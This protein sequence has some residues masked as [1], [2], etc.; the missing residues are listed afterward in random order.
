MKFIDSIIHEFKRGF[1]RVVEV[2]KVWSLRWWLYRHRENDYTEEEAA[3]VSA[4]MHVPP[5]EMILQ[6]KNTALLE[7]EPDWVRTKVREVSWYEDVS[8]Q[9]LIQQ[10]E[11]QLRTAS[12]HPWGRLN[13]FNIYCTL[14][15]RGQKERLFAYL[16]EAQIQK[17]AEALCSVIHC[18]KLPQAA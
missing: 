3:A 11:E 12:D 17:L 6:A 9:Q 5:D 7:Q 13:I 10:L 16:Q 8:T 1:Q 15:R 18:V 4:T 14:V 2:A